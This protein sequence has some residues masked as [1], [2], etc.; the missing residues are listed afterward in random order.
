[1]DRDTDW[2]VSL[3][4]SQLMSTLKN[5]MTTTDTKYKLMC[6]ERSYHILRTGIIPQLL[7]Q[8]VMHC[9]QKQLDA[10]HNLKQKNFDVFQH[11]SE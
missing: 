8:K 4:I 10:Q 2:A 9:L 11:V 5:G 1:M 7:E 3:E 6:L